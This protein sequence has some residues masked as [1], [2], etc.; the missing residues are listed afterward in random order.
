MLRTKKEGREQ[1]DMGEESPET[2]SLV[3][4]YYPIFFDGWLSVFTWKPTCNMVC[5]EGSGES[6]YDDWGSN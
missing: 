6:M 5:C 1:V 2:A 4:G 3:N